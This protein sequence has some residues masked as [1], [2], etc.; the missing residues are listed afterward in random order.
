LT[1][2]FARVAPYAEDNPRVER[3][4]KLLVDLICREG[5]PF[6]LVDSDAFREFVHELDPRYRI[7]DRHALSERLV[8]QRYETVK[9]DIQAS[10]S[11]SPAHAITTDMWTSSNN[12][13]YMGVT[14]HWLDD[15]FSIHNKCL[16]VRPAPG[17]H[18]AD[19]IST[20][21]DAVLTEWSIPTATVTAVTDSGANVKKALAN[22]AVERW[23]PCFAHTLQLCVNGSLTQKE[24][25]ELPKIMAKARAIVGHFRRSP[26]AT[27]QLERAQQQLDL[28]RHKLLQDCATRWNSQCVMLERLLEQRDAVSLVLASVP[29]VK[30]LSAQQWSTAAELTSTLR[31]FLEVTTLM[32]GASYPTISMIVPVVDGLQHL[33]KN[34]AGGLD[35]LRS[36]LA[37][38]VQDKFGDV[39]DDDQLCVATVVDP[40]FKLAPFDHADRRQ[41]AVETTVRAME[42]MMPSS[43]ASAPTPDQST[44]VVADQPAAPLSLWS[45]LDMASTQAPTSNTTDSHQHILRRELQQFTDVAVIPRS[46]CPLSWW[47]RN[48][49][50]YPSVAAVARRLL[51]IPATSVPSERLFSKAGD[52]IS[53]KRN[54]LAPSKAD[55]VVFLM[56]NLV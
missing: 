53:K 2:T 41:R 33:L 11:K 28:P 51:A 42:K 6:S 34:T 24:V 13:S 22:M 52:V 19:F 46:D 38:M 49:I 43:A 12:F 55:R 31:P 47:A 5:L 27:T 16:A 4:N 10:L 35:V 36:V 17:S 1:A 29:T 37:R 8:L 45:K 56:D 50:T 14:A 40:R 9:S 44:T 18:T 7:P 20:E 3:L 39:F 26:L 21:L 25:S 54:R 48:K 30:N 32:S 15:E 23:R